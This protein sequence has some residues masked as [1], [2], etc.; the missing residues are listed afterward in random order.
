M[1]GVYNKVYPYFNLYTM[2]NNNDNDGSGII[3][4]IHT[5]ASYDKNSLTR[6]RLNDIMEEVFSYRWLHQFPTL[7]DAV[8]ESIDEELSKECDKAK[9]NGILIINTPF[10]EPEYENVI[11][12]GVN[13]IQFEKNKLGSVEEKREVDDSDNNNIQVPSV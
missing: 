9:A 4:Q 12:S 11:I 7:P 1:I 6:S 5:V 10:N 2:E 3:T 8:I 13:V